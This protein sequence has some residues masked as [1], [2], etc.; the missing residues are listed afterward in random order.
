MVCI[1][2]MILL[3]KDSIIIYD[4]NS[5]RINIFKQPKAIASVF[6]I[7]NVDEHIKCKVCGESIQQDNKQFCNKCLS[8]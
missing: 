6:S 7:R 8:K 1:E 2:E 4:K 3:D 5:K